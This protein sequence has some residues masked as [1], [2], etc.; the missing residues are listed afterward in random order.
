MEEASDTVLATDGRRVHNLHNH[1]FYIPDPTLVFIGLPYHVSTFNLYDFQAIAVA[2]VFSGRA[3]LLSEEEMREEYRN[4]LQVKGS[5]KDFHSLRMKWAM[6]NHC[7]IGLTKM[8]R[9]KDSLPSVATQRNG[10]LPR[11]STSRGSH[12]SLISL[13]K[14]KLHLLSLTCQPV[15]RQLRRQIQ[16]RTWE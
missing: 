8:P 7:W 1:I 12:R 15:V 9:R 16:H 3:A 5:D 11:Q 6:S 2:A 14:P 4:Y 13:I 10:M